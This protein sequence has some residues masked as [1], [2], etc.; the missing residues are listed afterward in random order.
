VASGLAARVRQSPARWGWRRAAKQL[1]REGHRVNDKR[2]QRLWRAEGL[3]VPYRKRKRPHRGIG[4]AVGAFCPAAPNALWA[5]DFQFDATADHRTLKLLNI[6][7]EFTR[8]CPAIVV[9]R[10]IDADKVVA[11]LDAIALTRARRRSSASTTAPSSSPA[12]SPTGAVQ[13]R[14][15]RVHRPRL[16]VAKRLDRVVQQA[17]TRRAAHGLGFR[18][19]A[20]GPNPH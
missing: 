19:A 3:K 7:D 6:V 2:M 14:Q 5:M 11:T 20:R 10:H 17:T 18:P 9:D 8:E 4:S 15:H 13:R 12:L 16:A 1:R